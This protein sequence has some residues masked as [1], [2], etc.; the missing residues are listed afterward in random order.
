MYMPKKVNNTKKKK[1]I[2]IRSTY[3]T[4]KSN[5]EFDGYITI[6]LQLI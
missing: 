1:L 3:L 2:T 5:N 6:H 4:V